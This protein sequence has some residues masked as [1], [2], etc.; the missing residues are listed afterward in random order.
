MLIVALINV[1][2][3]NESR[4][5]IPVGTEPDDLVTS[6]LARVQDEA[7]YLADGTPIT[8]AEVVVHAY[9][10]HGGYLG[11]LGPDGQYHAQVAATAIGH[12]P[13]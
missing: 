2:D 10:E 7:G 3:I 11:F 8:P 12:G 5:G 9:T 4:H 13:L 1:P 6:V